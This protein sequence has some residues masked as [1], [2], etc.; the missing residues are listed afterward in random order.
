MNSTPAIIGYVYDPGFRAAFHPATLV[1][2]GKATV[3]VKIGL[4]DYTF[5]LPY[6]N[7]WDRK[8][9]Y[10]TL[11]EAREREIKQASRSRS[12]FGY[13]LME[14]GQD[15]HWRRCYLHLDIATVEAHIAE[16]AEADSRKR[17]V[18]ALTSEI[19]GKATRFARSAGYST[20]TDEIIAELETVLAS[21]TSIE[22]RVF[23]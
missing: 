22:E 3:T 4:A 14:R 16:R 1:K 18:A 17:K 19:E 21:L 10:L 6:R 9:G 7:G 20:F 12:I 13:G 23:A 8:D 5:N 11:A 2:E 15:A